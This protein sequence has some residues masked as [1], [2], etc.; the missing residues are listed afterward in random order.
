MNSAKRCVALILAGGEGTR[1]GA[2]TAEQAKPA[3]SFGGS[4]RIIDFTLNNCSRSEIKR[5]GVLT[6]YKPKT[7][8][9]HL[10]AR[11]PSGL[12]IDCLQANQSPYKG[13]ADAVFKNLSYLEEQR[14]THVLILSGD[15]IYHM[16]YQEMLHFHIQKGAEVTVASIQVP[17]EEAYR[18]G[19]LSVDTNNAITSFIE[20]PAKPISNM[21]SMGIYLFNWKT[22]KQC[23]S[24]DSTLA[25]SNHD[26]GKN[27]IPTLLSKHSKLFAFLFNQYWRDV[28]TI[29]SYWQAQMEWAL[30]SQSLGHHSIN[31][32]AA[33]ETVTGK[34]EL[35]HSVVSPTST[36]AE[37]SKI[38]QSVILPGV[39][40]GRN[41]YLKKAIVAENTHIPDN[42][43]FPPGE[44][45]ML[46]TQ[47]M[48]D[49]YQDHSTYSTTQQLYHS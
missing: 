18:Y 2:L 23:L 6:Q 45:I 8:H 17:L 41:V 31:V 37:S 48:V 13:T 11:Q 35:S 9:D 12:S 7:L 19:I 49:A 27:I 40:I 32:P 33:L 42:F 46:I 5:A 34:I 26:F 44:E 43:A 30:S 3:V 47:A 1:L 29:Q 20:K 22:L 25:H 28:G 10:N 4:Y 36:I 21:A 24:Y 16:N 15:H 14:P 38:D 39:T